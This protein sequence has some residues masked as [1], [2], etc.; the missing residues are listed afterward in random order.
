MKYVMPHLQYLTPISHRDFSTHLLFIL[1]KALGQCNDSEKQE[2][3]KPV[4][5]HSMTVIILICKHN[6]NLTVKTLSLLTFSLS[7]HF[8]YSQCL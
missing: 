8:T 6:C 7:A 1:F 3:A 5:S 4:Q 2:L